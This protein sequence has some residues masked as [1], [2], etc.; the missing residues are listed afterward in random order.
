MEDAYL[1]NHSF[2]CFKAS[3]TMIFLQIALELYPYVGPYFFKDQS[4]LLSGIKLINPSLI[5]CF[6]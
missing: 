2:R 3:K 6:G 5:S 1:E 4:L